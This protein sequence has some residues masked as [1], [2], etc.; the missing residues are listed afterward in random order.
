MHALSSHDTGKAP[1]APERVYHAF[2]LGLLVWLAPR[3]RVVSNRESGYGRSDVMLIP[4]KPGQPGVVIELKAVATRRGE[5][6]RKAMNAALRQLKDRDYAAELRA[7]G[8]SPVRE[9]G[10]VFEGKNVKVAFAKR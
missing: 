4:K 10:V 1:G 2:V 3:Y 9:V 6:L 7:A 8:A 5:T